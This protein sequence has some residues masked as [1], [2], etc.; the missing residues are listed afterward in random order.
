MSIP[1]LTPRCREYRS[2]Y[3]LEPRS[4]APTPGD[5]PADHRRPTGSSDLWSIA[6]RIARHRLRCLPRRARPG[7]GPATRPS[8]GW[9]ATGF[10][11]AA[12]YIRAKETEM[13]ALM[14]FHCAV[15]L[16][17]VVVRIGTVGAPSPA[18]VPKP[19]TLPATGPLAP[20]TDEPAV[21]AEVAE[22][23]EVTESGKAAGPANTAEPGD[24]APQAT[25]PP[26]DATAE[27]PASPA[28]ASDPPSP[29]AASAATPGTVGAPTSTGV[30]YDTTPGTRPRTQTQIDDENP[31]D[32]ADDNDDKRVRNRKLNFKRRGTFLSLSA[33]L[34]NCREDLCADIQVAGHGR[35]EIGYRLGRFSPFVGVS[36][37]GSKIDFDDFDTDEEPVRDGT[38]SLRFLDV[39]AGVQFSPNKEGRLDP[40]FVAALGYSR[41]REKLASG[42]RSFDLKISRG[43][44]RLGAGLAIYVARRVALAP[45]FDIV[46]PF[47]GKL[48]TVADEPLP[49][50]DFD[51]CTDV[52]DLVADGESDFGKRSV[53]RSLPRPWSVAADLRFVF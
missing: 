52:S 21:S 53:R 4:G 51:E 1:C 32:S 22:P 17:A 27:T 29:L 45:R 41:V 34:A 31:L 12:A 43:G 36:L 30:S 13:S 19:P 3:E 14:C 24:A 15:L 2:F 25:S 47:E 20:A 10:E 18:T 8:G 40:F 16:L 23:G 37:G 39:G 9:P 38:G 44:L 7:L 5:D 48:C 26:M 42:A 49:S 6:R 11:A 35:F 46:L 28:A 50:D 33:G